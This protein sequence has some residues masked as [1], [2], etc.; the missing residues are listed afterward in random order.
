[1]LNKNLNLVLLDISNKIIRHKNDY[2]IT[3]DIDTNLYEVFDSLE[4]VEFIMDLE[5]E[6]DIVIPDEHAE[7]IISNGVTLKD[8]KKELEVYGVIDIREQRK[9]KINNINNI[10]D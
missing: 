6:F 7:K 2:Q 10:N 1:M 8:V 4:S 9:D 3:I 5:K